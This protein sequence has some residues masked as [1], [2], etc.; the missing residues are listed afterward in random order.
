MSETINQTRTVTIAELTQFPI[1]IKFGTGEVTLV[2]EVEF[3][4]DLGDLMH[5]QG[6]YIQGDPQGDRAILFL[7]GGQRFDVVE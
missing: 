4:H 6:Y 5:C 2:S 7:M 3:A 1:T